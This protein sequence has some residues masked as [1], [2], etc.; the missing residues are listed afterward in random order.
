MKTLSVGFDGKII[1]RNENKGV[2]KESGDEVGNFLP[3][4]T[5]NRCMPEVLPL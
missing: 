4:V 1:L 5:S 3:G 2:L